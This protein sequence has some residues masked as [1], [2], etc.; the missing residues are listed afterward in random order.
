LNLKGEEGLQGVRVDTGF[1]AGDSVTPYYDPMIAKVIVHGAT[2]AEALAALMKEL[3]DAVVIGPKTNLGFLRAL[4][5]SREFKAGT[6]DTGFIDANL[7][8]LGAQ[9]HPPDKRAVHAAARLLLERRDEGRASPLAP[10]DPWR[11]ADSFELVGSRRIGLDVAVDGVPMR[12]HL[13]EGAN[14]DPVTEREDGGDGDEI[15]LHEANGGV[16]AFAG[17]RQAFVQLVDPFAKAEAGAGEGDAA[18]RAPMNGRLVKVAVEEGERVEAGQRLAVVEAMKMEHALVAPHAGVVRDL[19]A[20][21]GDQVE[22]GEAIMR[23]EAVGYG[24][25]E[26]AERG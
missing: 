16:Y 3:D 2:R 7:G 13:V 8:R 6:I 10:F 21:L 26:V 23:V 19:T 9:P 15:T 25:G 24:Q 20:A 4:L 22:M 11:V 12:V 1:A 5:R 17:G 18:V 14:V